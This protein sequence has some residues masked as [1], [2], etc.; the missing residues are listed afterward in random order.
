MTSPNDNETKNGAWR[1]A[2]KLPRNVLIISLVSF[3][4]DASSEMIYPLLPLFLA[5]TLNASPLAI[6][7]IEGASESL[8]SFLKLFSGYWSDKRGRRKSF[9]V[10]GYA[11]AGVARPLIG[12]TTSWQQV[13]SI[14]LIDRTGKGIRS[15]PR[16]AMI[17]DSCSAS[18]RGLA[19]GFHRA[20]D[21]A[22]AVAG[23]V[24]GF[25][26][27]SFIAANP[28]APTAKDYQTVFLLASI[29]ALASVIVAA[30]LIK[31]SKAN[32]HT[33]NKHAANNDVAPLVEVASFK[34]EADDASGVVLQNQVVVT[35]AQK[36]RLTWSGFDANFKRLLLIVALFTLSN[37]T[38]AF[39]LTRAQEAGVSVASLPLLWAALHVCKVASSVFGGD[40][41]DR[42]GR[43]R[44]IAAGWLIYALVY[45]CFAFV[46]AA[47]QVWLLFLIYGIYFGLTE[48]V[49]KAF[50]A[51]LTAS[52]KH[53]TA[54]GLYNLAFSITVFPA[55][56]LFGL[57]W[58]LYGS[59]TAFLA[60]ASLSL[61]AV[62]L[63][64]LTVQP[65]RE[66]VKL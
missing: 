28:S 44:V 50:V 14:R 39:L 40:L 45:A 21:H 46:V 36:W 59:Q 23:P 20:L 8:S 48:G 24:L 56:L 15:A 64:M 57:V 63:L 4:N 49:E 60:S 30:F 7:I 66:R 47:W 32:N 54:F 1:R 16:D 13:L 31:E 5:L 33:A 17:A 41:S 3:L 43:K 26:F 2:V 61:I 19:F 37:S 18:E 65:K 11:L 29:P 52:E 12:L 51:D 35:R 9:V 22:G 10:A 53:G 6:G 38:D 58:K 25:I 27:L 55:S 34:G 62:M 42:L